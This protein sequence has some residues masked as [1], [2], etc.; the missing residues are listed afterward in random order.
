MTK[1][2]RLDKYI[3]DLDNMNLVNTDKGT[4]YK[5]DFDEMVVRKITIQ[6]KAASPIRYDEN[7]DSIMVWKQ[8]RWQAIEE[9]QK[10]IM[11]MFNARVESTLL[12]N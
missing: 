6:S 4:V 10:A 5:F 1:F 3:V 12:G 11:Y 2:K 9:G 7:T 8:R